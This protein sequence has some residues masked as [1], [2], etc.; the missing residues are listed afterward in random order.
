MA[1]VC[2]FHCS[3]SSIRNLQWQLFFFGLQGKCLSSV[4]T[5]APDEPDSSWNT[6]LGKACLDDQSTAKHPP[7]EAN[8]AFRDHDD[9]LCALVMS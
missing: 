2:A 7:T 4:H 6:G 3:H 9:Q 1:Y 8:K 5:E